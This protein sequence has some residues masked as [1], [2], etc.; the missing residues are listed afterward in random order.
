MDKTAN[1]LMCELKKI[2]VNTLKRSD[3]LNHP[4]KDYIPK[5]SLFENKRFNSC[6]IIASAGSLKGSNLGPYISN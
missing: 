5:R 3:I 1:E 2:S 4:L 6:A